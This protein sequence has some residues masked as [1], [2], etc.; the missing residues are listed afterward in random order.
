MP[1][2][3]ARKKELENKNLREWWGKCITKQIENIFTISILRML[4]PQL[5]CGTKV[6][7]STK[8]FVFI[9]QR[10]KDFYL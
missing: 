3:T 1:I 5:R 10:R 8:Q 7:I 4:L 9:R 6:E 2:T